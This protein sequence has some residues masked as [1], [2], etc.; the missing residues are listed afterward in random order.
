MNR[1]RRTGRLD[2]KHLPLRLGKSAARGPDI[3]PIPP[4]RASILN[5]C[6]LPTHPGHRAPRLV[7]PAQ[8]LPQDFRETRE[9][10]AKAR[11]VVG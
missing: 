10:G 3:F 6:P 2:P 9:K 4:P 8:P 1:I 5:L 7:G 11:E